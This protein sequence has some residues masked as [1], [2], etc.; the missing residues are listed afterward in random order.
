MTRAWQLWMREVQAT[1]KAH[2]SLSEVQPLHVASGLA[3]PRLL[4]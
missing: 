1:L 3:E 2:E 4:G